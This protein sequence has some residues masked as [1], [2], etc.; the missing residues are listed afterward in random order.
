MKL[1]F[2]GLENKPTYRAQRVDEIK[3]VNCPRIMFTSGVTVIKTS[4]VAQSH[5]SQFGH[6]IYMYLKEVIVFFQK[7]VWSSAEN[8][9]TKPFFYILMTLTPGV[10]MITRQFT[11]FLSCTLWA[12]SV[13]VFNFWISRT[14]KFNSMG[15]RIYIRFWSVKYT[16]LCQRLHFQAC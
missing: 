10:N 2:E 13:D 5:H 1:N 9:R 16:F 6:N 8:T 12:L 15:F 4:N 11:P 7:I 3:G 14:S